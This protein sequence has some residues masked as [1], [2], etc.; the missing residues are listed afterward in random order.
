MRKKASGGASRG[1]PGRHAAVPVQARPRR[2]ASP[3]PWGHALWIAGLAAAVRVVYLLGAGHN[4]LF[5][6]P[7]LDA[8]INDQLG[9][10]IA[11]GSGPGAG[12]Y[13]RPP[14]YPYFIAAVYT[15]FG[16]AFGAVRLVQAL[17][18]VGTALLVGAAA[19]EVGGRRA[20][21]IAGV[22][23]ALYGPFVYFDAELVSASLEV[24]LVAASV[25]LALVAARRPGAWLVVAA[26]LALGAAV[27][28]RPT[29]LPVALVGG[30]WLAAAGGARAG[31]KAAAAAIARHLSLYAAAVL[32]LPVAATVRNGVSSGD[33]VFVAS[34]GGINFYIGNNPQADG[35]TPYVPGQ[36]T[37][38]T[39]TYEAPA[40]LASQ[41]AG[42]TLRPSEVSSYWFGRGFEIWRHDPARALMLTAKKIALVWNRRELPN[43]QDSKFFGP[44]NS[45]LF[46][47]PGLPA[48]SWIAPIGLVALWRERRRAWLLLGFLAVVTLA[49]AAFFVCDRFRLPLAI[50]LVAGAGLGLDRF[51]EVAADASRGGRAGFL[52]GALSAARARPR[53]VAALVILGAAVVLPF[54][55]LQKTESGMSWFRLATALQ[56]DGD[57]LAT[58]QA[59]ARAEKEGF[60]T[61]EFYNNWGLFEMR[62]RQSFRAEQHLRRALEINPSMGP[63]RGNLGELYA[64]REKWEAAAQEF[65]IAAPLIPEKTAELY[66]NAGGLYAGI[67]KR[68]LAREMYRRALAARPGF[69]Q[70]LAGLARLDAAEATP[71]GR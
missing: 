37:G 46:R 26:G 41:A 52:A 4:P 22:L 29:Y 58:E 11:S 1:R 5:R 19:R 69:A 54:P 51:L 15:L 25:W 3:S 31:G 56:Q 24:F 32:L 61:A 18:G 17:L 59:Y 30:A 2:R 53:T 7:Q 39:S 49:V 8:A 35:I 45:W 36:G 70:A 33:W 44:Y 10:G 60:G 68:E 23:A 34:Q 65:S 28:T 6:H 64:R 21:L 12:P 9:W 13:F 42:R 27:V 63:A 38:I 47:V 67:G 43:N 20:G 55:R 48:F 57:V 71:A 40:R 14:G 66:T 62:S 50:A 16:H